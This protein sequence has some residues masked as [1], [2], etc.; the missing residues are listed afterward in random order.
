MPPGLIDDDDGMGTG[1]DGCG[2]FPQMKGHGGGVASG[3]HQGRADAPGRA[4]GAEDIG[5]AGSLIVGSRGASSPFRPASCDLVFLSDPGFVLPPDF[6]GRSCRE[7]VPDFRHSGGEVFLN[8]AT[9]SEFCVWWR[10]RA[11]SFR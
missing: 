2:D 9:A 4:D 1:R 3:E 7:I 10:G 6:Y 5:R 11:E 8:A